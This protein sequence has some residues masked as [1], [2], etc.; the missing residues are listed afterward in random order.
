MFEKISARTAMA[1]LIIAA[2]FIVLVIASFEAR[3]QQV[4]ERLPNIQALPAFEVST[5]LHPVFRNPELRFSVT[6][7]NVGEGPLEFI[8]GE[9]GRGKQNIYQRIYLSDGTSYDRRVGAY[10]WHPEH[11]HIHVENYAEYTLQALNAPGNSKRTGQKT[12]FCVMDTDR[13]DTTI[14]SDQAH[15]TTCENTV[16]GMSVGWGDTYHS[17]LAGQEIDL[18]GL[19]DGDYTLTVKA[20][21]LGRMT[22]ITTTDNTSCI[23]LRLAG[24]ATSPSVT[25]LNP[26]SCSAG[27]GGG[28]PVTV[29][30]IAPNSGKIGDLL[31]VDI[32]GTGFTDGIAVSF[33]NGSGAKLTVS[34]VVVESATAISALVTIQ[35]SGNARNADTVWDLR[36]GNAVLS[37]A[38]VVLP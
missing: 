33:Q 10:V 27:G 5:R 4:V 6:T 38:F 16:Q 35:K 1:G 2:G 30:S 3:A 24:I 23:K 20:D 21:P 36:V 17:Q 18:T 14:G 37:E 8:G 12:S 7:V 34:D 11:N 15:Y 28:G 9:T 13:I 22:E 29:T 19:P 26:T 32:T 31:A 25:V